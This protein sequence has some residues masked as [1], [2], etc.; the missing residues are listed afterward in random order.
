MP[1]SGCSALHGVNLNLKKK[2][3]KKKF[4]VYID[5]KIDE[6][7]KQLKIIKENISLYDVVD[8]PSKYFQKS[9]SMLQFV[10][11]C[12]EFSLKLCSA[13]EFL[14]DGDIIKDIIEKIVTHAG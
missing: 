1:R 4:A 11:E 14:S 12:M 8:A 3:K 10:S 2:K 13:N 6:L 7:F 5:N 9:V